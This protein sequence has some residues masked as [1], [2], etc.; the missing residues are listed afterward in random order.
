MI[1]FVTEN[2]KDAEI[3]GIT[4]DFCVIVLVK[5]EFVTENTKWCVMNWWCLDDWVRDRIYKSSEI[6]GATCELV[7][8]R[9]GDVQIIEFVTEYT[10]RRNSWRYL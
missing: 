3:R 1:E 9:I 8:D 6:R 2:T 10:S 4:R 5:I 7:C